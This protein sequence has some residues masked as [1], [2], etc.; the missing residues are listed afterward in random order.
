M[1]LQ[2][3][4]VLVTGGAHGIGKAMVERFAAEGAAVICADLHAAA[5]L[6]SATAA[7]VCHVSL[8]VSDAG[9][10]QALEAELTQ[11]GIQ[12]DCLVNNAGIVAGL[13]ITELDLETWQRIL[14]VN[15][16]GA[17]LGCQLAIRNMQRSGG[18]SI[19][20]VA[21]TVAGLGLAN[22]AA[23]TAS[24]AGLAGLTRSI[25]THCALERMNIRCNSLSPGPTRTDI[26]EKAIAADPAVAEALERMTPGGRLAAPDEIA[27]LA[28]F[29]AS[30]D[31]SYCNGANFLADGGLSSAH[32]RM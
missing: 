16:T 12:L 10:W 27:S 18:G 17:M 4:T 5:G 28:V 2:N 20:N 13:P 8:D 21:S 24:K 11:S 19:I 7:T 30:D 1:R 3:K 25:A 32:P 9:S 29:L 22:D 26:L 15:L 14:A 6:P 23:Y 31:A